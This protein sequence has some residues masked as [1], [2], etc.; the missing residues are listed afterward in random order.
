MPPVRVEYNMINV[1]SVKYR[2]DEFHI[3]YCP[4][5]RIDK[6]ILINVGA[7]QRMMN[8]IFLLSQRDNR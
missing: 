2:H 3:I 1:K 6:S 8:S 4:E 7:G 5:G